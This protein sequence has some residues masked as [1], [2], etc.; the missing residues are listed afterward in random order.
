ML[1]DASAG[2]TTSAGID[3]T[4]GPMRGLTL[5]RHP[6]YY[7]CTY[8][9]SPEIGN[10]S[11]ITIDFLTAPARTKSQRPCSRISAR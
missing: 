2:H 5:L 3:I 6:S 1:P 7:S 9:D 8:I 10:I 11:I 4:L